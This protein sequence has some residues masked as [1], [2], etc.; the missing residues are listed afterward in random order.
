MFCLNKLVYFNFKVTERLVILYSLGE[1]RKEDIGCVTVQFKK[2]SL[3]PKFFE[4]GKLKA[5][6]LHSQGGFHG[7]C[8][9]GSYRYDATSVS[10]FRLKLSDSGCSCRNLNYDRLTDG[11]K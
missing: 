7:I 10:V 1:G 11:G 8:T 6:S 2:M 4:L 5:V 3:F 9:A